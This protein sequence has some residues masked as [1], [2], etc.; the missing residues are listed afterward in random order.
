MCLLSAVS[1]IRTK[2]GI[3]AMYYPAALEG[4]PISFWLKPL[5]VWRK[6]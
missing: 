4:E 5:K 6:I 1:L 3:N 2:S